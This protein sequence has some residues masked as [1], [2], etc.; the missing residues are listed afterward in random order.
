MEEFTKQVLRLGDDYT[1]IANITLSLWAGVL[2]RIQDQLSPQTLDRLYDL[3]IHLNIYKVKEYDSH[4][5]QIRKKELTDELSLLQG[6]NISAKQ[7]MDH[8]IPVEKS[9]TV[10]ELAFLR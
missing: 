1:G 10:E 5:S 2:V 8:R 7:F 9:F 6:A 3:Y 4:L